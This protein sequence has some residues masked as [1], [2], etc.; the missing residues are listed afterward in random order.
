MEDWLEEGSWSYHK[1]R[2]RSASAWRIQDR[3]ARVMCEKISRKYLVGQIFGAW[4][5]EHCIAGRFEGECSDK[6]RLGQARLYQRGS[7]TVC[8]LLR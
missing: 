8:R 4:H 1:G 7:H 6:L 2:A 5:I 3:S